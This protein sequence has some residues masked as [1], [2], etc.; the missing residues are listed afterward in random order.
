[1]TLYVNTLLDNGISLSGI[2]AGVV[3]MGG[4][5]DPERVA[6]HKRDHWHPKERTE[7][8]KPTKRD[9]AT[10]VRDKVA[11]AVEEL[12]GEALL[13]MGKEL[14]PMVGKGLQAEAIIDKRAVNDAKLGLAAGALSLQAWLAGLGSNTAPP[15]ELDDGMT[16]EGEAVEVP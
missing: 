8:P 4:K 3:D 15:A 7:G 13:L 2:A 9:L 5:L 10:L 16:I 6:R 1:M 12:S 14:G 11:D